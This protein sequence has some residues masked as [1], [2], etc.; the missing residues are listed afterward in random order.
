LFYGTPLPGVEQEEYSGKLIVLEGADGVGRSTHIALLR[1]WLESRGHAVLDTGMTRSVLAGRGLKEAKM[2][3]TLGRLT[4]QLFYA[5]DF[6]D[7]L[8]NEMLSALRAGFIVLTDRYIYSAIA[9]AEVRGIDPA[10]IRSIYGMALVPD[11][12]FYLRVQSVHQLVERVLASGRRF[13]YWESGRDLLLGADFYESFIEYQ[14]R[15]LKV[16][17][18]MSGEYGFQVLDASSSINRVAARLR[19]MVAKVIDQRPSEKKNTQRELESKTTPST[20]VSSST[21]ASA[22]AVP[23]SKKAGT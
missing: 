1:A 2:G 19:R 5:T 12:I 8:E 18:R 10:W 3:H 11:A 9:R 16:F 22:V 13:D 7:R 20:T 23:R 17:D 15:M 21:D 14:S 6:V 4:M